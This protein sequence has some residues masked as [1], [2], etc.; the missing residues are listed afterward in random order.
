MA[1]HIPPGLMS[2]LQTQI[3]TRRKSSWETF[4][5]FLTGSVHFLHDAFN[6]SRQ[7]AAGSLFVLL[8]PVNVVQVSGWSCAPWRPGG[9]PKAK[10]TKTFVMRR[11]RRRS[12]PLMANIAGRTC[13]TH[14]LAA[15]QSSCRC[16][17][18]VAAHVKGTTERHSHRAA[19][20]CG[21]E[22]APGD[23]QVALSN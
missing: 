20:Y 6:F 11:R 12:C 7:C 15:F 17:I 21:S 3:A 18:C 8:T 2:R 19:I 4:S 13:I 16:Y 5:S 23:R 10:N 1:C 22:C 9:G 14:S